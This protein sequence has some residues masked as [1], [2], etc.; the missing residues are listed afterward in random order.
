MPTLP[1]FGGSWR[2]RCPKSICTE[3]FPA[4]AFRYYGIVANG[5][6]HSGGGGTP[7]SVG[8]FRMIPHENYIKQMRFLDFCCLNYLRG[9]PPPPK[10]RP[11]GGSVT[12]GILVNTGLPRRTPGAFHAGRHPFLCFPCESCL[13]AGIKK[14]LVPQVLVREPVMVCPALPGTSPGLPEDRYR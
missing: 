2:M 8:D 6:C 12:G 13:N 9:T 3:N 7:G 11:R 1:P 5:G 10:G 4:I 14:L